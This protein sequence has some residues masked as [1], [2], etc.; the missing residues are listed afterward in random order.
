M[1]DDKFDIP[2]IKKGKYQHYKGGLYEVIDIA[3]HSETLDWYVVYKPLYD[4]TGKPDTWIRP[5]HMFFEVVSHE[6]KS[7][8]RFKHVQESYGDNV[9]NG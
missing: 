9:Y 7:M 2:Q 6:G 4:H 3:C 1:S 8:P 5:Y